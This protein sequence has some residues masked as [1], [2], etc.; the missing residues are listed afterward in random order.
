MSTKQLTDMFEIRRDTNWVRDVMILSDDYEV[1][2]PNWDRPKHYVDE[3]YRQ[4]LRD[5]ERL[6]NYLQA[7][8][9]TGEIRHFEDY[10]RMLDVMR[11]EV[12]R[13][14]WWAIAEGAR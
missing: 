2:M 4:A 8:V 13:G 6:Q 10:R 1:A 9:E 7:F 11:E 5:M 12:D 3:K 14:A